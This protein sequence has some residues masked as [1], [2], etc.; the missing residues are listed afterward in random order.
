VSP[1]AFIVT[2]PPPSCARHRHRARA[3]AIVS[4]HGT[5]AAPPRLSWLGVRPSGTHSPFPPSRA[6][7]VAPFRALR[8]RSR[9]RPPVSRT[10]AR[11]LS[12]TQAAILVQLVSNVGEVV[13]REAL[14]DAAWGNTA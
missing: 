10:Q 12:E 3:V 9:Q 5:A 2:A 8:A 6:R 1:P 11:P 13:S 7:P 14:I 4:A